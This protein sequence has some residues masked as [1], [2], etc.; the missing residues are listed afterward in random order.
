[1]YE[2]K[3]L[4]EYFLKALIKVCHQSLKRERLKVYIGPYWILVY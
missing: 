2:S 1:M 4:I 3:M